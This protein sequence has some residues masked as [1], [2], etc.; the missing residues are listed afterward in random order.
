MILFWS[1]VKSYLVR[2]LSTDVNLSIKFG[3][4][5]KRLRNIW[6]ASAFPGNNINKPH[7]ARINVWLF[8]TS[9]SAKRRS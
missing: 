4:H 9:R 8:S 1:K 7:N 3:T 6:N 2:R 5:S